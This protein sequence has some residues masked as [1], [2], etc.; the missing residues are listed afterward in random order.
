MSKVFKLFWGAL[1]LLWMAWG[2][3]FCLNSAG[4]Q[5][6]VFLG[7]GS[8][9]FSDYHATRE[10]PLSRPYHYVG[11]VQHE[12]TA[13]PPL[14]ILMAH[15]FPN[16]HAGAVLFTVISSLI[17]AV[18]FCIVTHHVC[19][20]WLLGLLWMFSSPFMF[21]LE[22]GNLVSI[23]SA[24]TILFLIWYDSDNQWKRVVAV[25]LLAFASSIKIAPGIFSILLIR[26]KDW[27]RL[28]LF[29][30][31]AIIL[32]LCPFMVLGGGWQNVAEF[33]QNATANTNTYLIHSSWGL[34]PIDRVLRAIMGL[35]VGQCW[36]HAG[37]ERHLTSLFGICLLCGSF[38]TKNKWEMLTLVTTSMLLIPGNQHFY[39]AIYLVP[40]TVWFLVDNTRSNWRRWVYLVLWVMIYMPLQIGASRNGTLNRPL[41]NISL[42]VMNCILVVEV[43]E[44][45]LRLHKPSG[46]LA[47]VSTGIW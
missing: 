2:I 20:S 34:I 14:A 47:D 45:K 18:S 9:C 43:I 46:D 40:A 11:K 6:H 22:R 25:F 35:D 17:L 16:G 4:A 41:A 3:G 12:K 37:V 23:S 33:L 30:C 26:Q 7:N 8:M 39:C 24:A 28:S 1:T 31:A 36:A 27:G 42:L 29:I 38:F 13:N 5:G 32:L 44:K 21:Q 19:K 15:C 10:A